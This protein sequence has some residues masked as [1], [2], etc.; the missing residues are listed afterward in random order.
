MCG[1]AG[2]VCTS[3]AP[4]PTHGDIERMTASLVH[5]GP[6]GSGTWLGRGVALGQRRLS[7]IDL[8]ENGRQPMASADGRLQLVC[9]GEIYNYQSLRQELSAAGQVF[10]SHTDVEVILPLYARHGD[11]VARHLVGMFAIGLWDEP[12][13]RL[14]LVRDRIGEKPL[15]YAEKGGRLAFA[16]EIKA[17]L[18]LPWIDREIDEEAVCHLFA[19]QSLP[20]PYTIY[21]GIRQLAPGEML[22]WENGATRRARYWNL[23]FSRPGPK[24]TERSALET[25]G[26]VMRDAVKGQLV[27]DVPVGVMLSG[28][29]DSTTIAR[30]AKEQDASV[31]TFCIGSPAD[32]GEDE[33]HRRA[34][35]AAEVLQTAHRNVALAPLTPQDLVRVLS[36][37]DQPCWS[38]VALYA[39][40]LARE[41][42][43]EVKVVLTGNGADEVFAG[44]SGYARLGPLDM[45]RR[46]ARPFA[47]LVP[48]VVGAGGHRIAQLLT[49]ARDGVAE[50]RSELLSASARQLMRQV[51]S[52]AYL[53]RWAG[54]EPGRVAAEAIRQSKAQSLLQ[55]ATCADL[56]VS[57]QHGHAVI[58][59]MSGMAHG[60][61]LRSPF[62]DHRVV[63]FAASL[64][65]LQLVGRRGR[66]ADTKWVAKQHLREIMPEDLVGARKIGFGYGIPMDRL[67]RTHWRP[68]I[69]WLLKEG[70]YLD[71]GIFSG[72]GAR[73]ALE[74]SYAATSLLVSFAVFAEVHL[75]GTPPAELGERLA[76]ACAP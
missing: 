62:L 24:W 12:R 23:D 65:P 3:E 42:R 54:A 36:H 60:L 72:E 33:E 28:G 15:Y 7:I 6:D 35:I 5:R 17:L 71:L 39:D 32:A 46:V 49:S 2:I 31:R 45:A 68:G 14:L 76:R 29:I 40:A 22:T 25:Y 74:T 70:R 51:A 69:E 11:D 8:S 63:E 66:A 21:R 26:R 1:I 16:S 64:Q 18:T 47:G 4:A 13:R 43:R 67:L 34:A 9:N 20:A 44:Y 57:H 37:Y 19:Y 73:R 27:A 30:F 61:E 59:D 52:D 10:Q 48:G 58:A 56:M 41:M 38:F 75:F 53:A 50:W 55:A